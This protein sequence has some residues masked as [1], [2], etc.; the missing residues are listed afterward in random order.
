MYYD[1]K[2]TETRVETC[3][4]KDLGEIQTG[5]VI[6]RKIS[7][8]SKGFKYKILTLKSVNDGKSL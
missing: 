1:N 4:L 7:D 5:L 6:K 2:K 8:N 3:K